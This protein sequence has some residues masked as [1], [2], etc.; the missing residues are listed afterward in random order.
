MMWR[1]LLVLTLAASILVA[2]TSHEE[3]L[4][5]DQGQGVYGGPQCSGSPLLNRVRIGAPADGTT[6]QGPFQV[7][8]TFRPTSCLLHE[9]QVHN[10]RPANSR[11]IVDTEMTPMLCAGHSPRVR[12]RQ[13][14]PE[15][16]LSP[17]L[18][19]C[20]RLLSCLVFSLENH[21]RISPL[22]LT[23]CL[24]GTQIRVDFASGH[25][26]SFDSPSSLASEFTVYVDGNAAHTS[27]ITDPRRPYYILSIP[28]L[29]VGV[30]VF[31]VAL[32]VPEEELYRARIQHRISLY[33]ASEE[34]PPWIQRRR[35]IA[36][37]EIA[38][39]V[40]GG[41]EG[42]SSDLSWCSNETAVLVLDVRPPFQKNIFPLPTLSFLSLSLSL[43]R[44]YSPCLKYT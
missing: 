2:G 26:P 20:P 12:V 31:E 33:S 41:G 17:S 38:V 36:C 6:V 11:V 7:M 3:D 32:T 42:G 37:K 39:P 19:L 13:G 34:S 24:G 22:V 29:P 44:N 4:L 9:L 15:S 28:G 8:N 10:F 43:S 25:V 35:K 27:P 18:L 23:L 1:E 40:R 16:S 5:P 14:P 21:W 30:H